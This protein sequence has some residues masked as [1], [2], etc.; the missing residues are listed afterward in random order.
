MRAEGARRFA[1]DQEVRWCPGCGDYAILKAM[2]QT[3]AEAGAEPHETVFVS[4]IGC[5][6]RFPYYMN[7]Y[8]LHTIHGR[9]PAF[10]TGLKS[11][12]P[13]LDVWVVTGDGDGMSIGGNHLLH[14]LRRNVDLQILLC[15]NQIYGLTK[16]Q[17]SPTSR[18]GLRTP[19]TPF[20]VGGEPADPCRFALGAGGTFIARSVDVHQRHLQEILAAAREHRGAALVE[21]LQNCPI[22]N[23]GAFSHLSDRATAEDACLRLEHGSPMIYGRRRQRGL[24]LPQGS[25]RVEAVEFEPDSPPPDLLVHDERSAAL[26]MLIAELQPPEFPVALGVL[27]RREA[28]VHPAA[29]LTPAAMESREDRPAEEVASLLRK[30]RVWSGG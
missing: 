9:A 2:R 4:G 5:A 27:H 13:D 12:R 20:G 15:N 14:A 6:A 25:L 24:R 10:A 22:Y 21:V 11:A 16:G 8:G 26:G 3:L 18:P 29:A 19:S 30:A 1:T 28:P 17:A 7:T 23:D